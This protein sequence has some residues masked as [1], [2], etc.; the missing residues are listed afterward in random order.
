MG[1]SVGDLG[2]FVL[3][4]AGVEIM[5]FCEQE[6][7]GTTDQLRQ[8]PVDVPGVF[9]SEFDIAHKAEIVAN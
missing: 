6:T 3:G 9:A 8:V 5:P 1:S 7:D 2:F 4:D